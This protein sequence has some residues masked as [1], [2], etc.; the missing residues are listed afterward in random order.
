MTSL[1][2]VDEWS[3]PGILD[4]VD[5]HRRSTEW[6]GNLWRQEDTLLLK[7]DAESRFTTDP[8]GTRLRLVRPFVDFDDQR[9]VLLGLY[10]ER[11]VFV[12]EALVDG[13]VHDLRQMAGQLSQVEREIA[14]QAIAVTNWHRAEPR[15][16][17]CGTETR[18]IRGGLGRHCDTCGKEVFLRTDPAVIVAVVDDRER[19]LLAG[20]RTWGTGRVSILAG[21]VEGGESLE[22][23]CHR[24]IAEE[25]DISLASVHYFG[26]QPWPM[27]RSLMVGFFARAATTEISVDGEEITYA[28]WFTRD[29]VREEVAAETLRLPG[30]ASIAHRII[31]A[32]LDGY[33][34]R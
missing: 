19:L 23:A 6:V 28:D 9:H 5:L 1:G 8:E 12:V 27:P 30:P 16:G 18:R 17:F 21:F 2:G 11:P 24:E 25:S 32:W 26:S 34:P 15:C 10:E 31:N 7:I 4:R 22:Q 13:P 14:T 20:Q 29:R 33:A 3:E